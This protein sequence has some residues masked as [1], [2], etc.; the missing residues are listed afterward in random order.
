MGG[1]EVRVKQSYNLQGTTH[2]D[3]DPVLYPNVAMTLM[4]PAGQMGPLPFN[5]YHAHILS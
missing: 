4:P 5:P 2:P 3:R 1:L